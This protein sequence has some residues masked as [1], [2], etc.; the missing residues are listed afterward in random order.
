MKKDKLA[1]EDDD[2]RPEY[3]LKTLRIRK[4]GSGRKGFG[5]TTVQLEPDV[6]EIFPDAHAV[7][8]ALRFLIRMMQDNR[9]AVVEVPASHPHTAND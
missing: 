6:A 9:T 3:D 5:V 1:I 7:N 8:E 2:L 4:L